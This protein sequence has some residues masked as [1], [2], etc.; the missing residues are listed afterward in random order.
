MVAGDGPRLERGA[1]ALRRARRRRS[2]AASPTRELD[3]LLASA[4][5][6]LFP[7]EEDFGIVPVEAQAAGVPVIAYGVGGVRDSVLDGDTG[8]L[9]D[10]QTPAALAA[11]IIAFEA[12]AARR[13]GLREN[14]R[15]FGPER[16]RARMGEVLRAAADDHPVESCDDPAH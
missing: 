14:A 9:F 8:V 1:S 7:G 3:E 12:L 10:R 11:A 15:R 13:A 2:S 4:R 6:L 5:A 16:F